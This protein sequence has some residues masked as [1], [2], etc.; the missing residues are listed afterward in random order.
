[1][2]SQ[3]ATEE[4]VKYPQYRHIQVTSKKY[5]MKYELI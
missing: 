5:G 1:M 3:E 2:E 4:E